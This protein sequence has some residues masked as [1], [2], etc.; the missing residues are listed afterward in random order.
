[1]LGPPELMVALRELTARARRGV[2]RGSD[3]GGAT[4]TVTS[5]GDHGADLVHGVIFPPQVALVG[6]GRIAE[7]P[8]AA[9][10]MVG[11]RRTVIATLAGDHRVSD[12]HSG[13][14]FL[15]SIDH[16]LQEPDQ[17]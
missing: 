3:M 10:G 4:L 14:L 12:G 2:L 1:M 15:A 16:H 5:L 8:F 9:G 11:A 17:L 13:S 6:F 7:R